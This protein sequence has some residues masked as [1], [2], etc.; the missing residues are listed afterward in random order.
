MSPVKA[1][2]LIDAFKGE[3]K[4]DA[5][6]VVAHVK[7]EIFWC[8]D[9]FIED[10][11]WEEFKKEMSADSYARRVFLSNLDGGMLEDIVYDQVKDGSSEL[12]VQQGHY[13]HNISLFVKEGVEV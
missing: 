13:D 10:G 3:D 2:E 7:V 6:N 9:D 5:I 1:E 4:E 11:E 12:E 8:R